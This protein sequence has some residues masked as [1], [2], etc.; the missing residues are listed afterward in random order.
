EA[1]TEGG[2]TVSD[3]PATP[4]AAAP[5]GTTAGET[6][7]PGAPSPSSV[8]S[9][10]VSPSEEVISGFIARRQVHRE[11]TRVSGLGALAEIGGAGSVVF[12]SG[13]GLMLS[14]V[15]IIAFILLCLALPVYTLYNLWAGKGTADE[16]ALQ[17]KRI[18]R[19]HWALL[20]IF[21]LL[22]F[23]SF[24]GGEYGSLAA[25]KYSSLGDS[26]GPGVL[27]GVLSWGLIVAL[28]ASILAA[29]KGAEI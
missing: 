13:L 17:L 20:A 12:S 18:L 4:A 24:F 2:L 23:L 21:G 22:V 14:G 9:E 28:A 10:Q 25:Q 8:Q 3:A 1:I 26:Y 5:A 19:Y 6:A 11:Y 7:A 27:L 29:A 16:Q 15:L